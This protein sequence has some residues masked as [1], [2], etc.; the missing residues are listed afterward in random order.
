MKQAVR[1]GTEA[2][3]G[4]LLLFGTALGLP[5]SIASAAVQPVRV[6][7][8]VDD[9]P[10]N[11]AD[12]PGLSRYR[13]TRGVIRALKANGLR[14]V[15]GFANGYWTDDNPGER[16]ALNAWLLA[17]FPLGNHTYDHLNLDEVSAS[18][19]TANITKMDLLLA[20]FA[21]VSPLIDQRWTFRF[22][23]LAE[24]DTI[25]KR[26][27]VRDY[28]SAHHYAIAEVTTDYS[29]WAWNAAYTRCRG[30]HN[31][32]AIAWLEAHIGDAALTRVREES[33][34]ARRL[35]GRDADQIMLVHDNALESLML[36]STLR[37][38]R[39]AGVVLV[40]LDEARK[41]PTYQ[42]NPD[43]TTQGGRAFFDQIGDQRRVDLSAFEESVYTVPKLNAICPTPPPIGSPTK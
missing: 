32:Q 33:A 38:L 24:G 12:I 23:Y 22:P 35:F 13:I 30:Q 36:A 18:A 21:S 16:A 27:A 29:D 15:Y 43:I 3:C 10:E 14:R 4:V 2:L 20:S 17:G 26:D 19:F 25:A 41:D 39:A 28:L 37:K 1:A 9:V 40:T 5:S 6:A 7:I 8:T 34:A 11:G 31:H 42:I